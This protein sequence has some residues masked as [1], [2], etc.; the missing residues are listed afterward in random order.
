MKNAATIIQQQLANVGIKCNLSILSG[1]DANKN[2]AGWGQGMWLHG[3]S[4]YVSAPM[5]M[6]SMFRQNLTG[7]VL[8]LTTLLRPDDVE[9]ALA[10]SVAAASE[11]EAIQ[12]VGEDNRLL[13]DEYCIIYN[14]AEVGTL[15]AV[16]P[17][18][19]DSGIGAT[20]YSVADLANAW[21]DK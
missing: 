15:Y 11:E 13:T 1:A 12:A 16:N 9:A 8:G 17:Y 21:L 19:K 7:H 20:F 3:S 14:F 2:E 10:L 5:Q 18:V 4:V 6:A